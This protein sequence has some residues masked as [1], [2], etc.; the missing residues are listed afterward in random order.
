MQ[1]IELIERRRCHRTE[2]TEGAQ[3]QNTNAIIN[4]ETSFS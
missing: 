2:E 1:L 4:H 3:K